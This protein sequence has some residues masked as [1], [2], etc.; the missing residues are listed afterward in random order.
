[1]TL[2]CD[3]RWLLAKTSFLC[4]FLHLA[5]Q[6]SL[7]LWVNQ[8]SFPKPW[9]ETPVRLSPKQQRH[10]SELLALV[11]TS[12]NLLRVANREAL[13]R[14]VDV[15]H[16]HHHPPPFIPSYIETYSHLLLKLE[17]R[18]LTCS[19]PD[20]M[21]FPELKSLDLRERASTGK[22]NRVINQFPHSPIHSWIQ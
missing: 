15:D 6:H 1:M 20:S 12:W 16:D 9:D 11:V 19:K 18:P 10:L 4:Q 3:S 21:D 22:L 7:S 14:T 5:S 17:T 8:K 2:D 13:L